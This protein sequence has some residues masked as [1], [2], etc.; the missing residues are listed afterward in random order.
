MNKKY[1]VFYRDG[2]C[3]NLNNGEIDRNEVYEV[4]L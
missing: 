3:D 4:Y 1:D 2:K